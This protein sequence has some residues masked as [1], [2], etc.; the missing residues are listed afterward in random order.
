MGKCQCQSVLSL[1][2]KAQTLCKGQLLCRAMLMGFTWM[3]RLETGSAA[4][5]FSDR[6]LYSRVFGFLKG[7]LISDRYEPLSLCLLM[8]PF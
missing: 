1:F 5:D 3:L 4:S 2:W 6:N 7:D 8:I